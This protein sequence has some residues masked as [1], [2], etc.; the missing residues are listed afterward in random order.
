MNMTSHSTMTTGMTI[1][2]I[3][4]VRAPGAFNFNSPGNTCPVTLK[5]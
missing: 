3:E 5:L 1:V 2:Q 4:K